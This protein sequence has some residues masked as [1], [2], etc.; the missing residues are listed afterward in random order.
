V[1]SIALANSCGF[2]VLPSAKR[3]ERA[4]SRA[5]GVPNIPASANCVR[6]RPYF[7]PVVWLVFSPFSSKDLCL[8][9]SVVLTVGN[10]P[11]PVTSVG[12]ADTRSWKDTRPNLV[13]HTFQVS[14]HL[15]EDHP[16]IPIKQAANV[17]A[18]DEGRGNLRYDSTHLGPQVALV[19]L[20][21]P[22]SG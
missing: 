5:V 1:G 21:Q 19:V 10:K 3:S 14:A 6:C 4:W 22:L 9:L 16:S 18:H 8:W 20:S 2:I 13:P 7:V 17:F 15:F 12:C 11:N